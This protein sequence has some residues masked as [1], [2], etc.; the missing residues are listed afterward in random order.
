MLD[1]H[2]QRLCTNA[3]ALRTIPFKR[4]ASYFR[5]HFAFLGGG[6]RNNDFHK[7]KANNAQEDFSDIT[8]W[9]E[10]MWIFQFCGVG[11]WSV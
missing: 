4:D 7:A 3:S 11:A 2:K 10:K 1:P 5:S 8:T 9:G 6:A